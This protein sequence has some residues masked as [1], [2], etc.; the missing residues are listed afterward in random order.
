[1]TKKHFIE[2]AKSIKIAY[3]HVHTADEKNAITYTT[4][5]LCN[6]FARFNPLFDEDRFL[7]ACGIRV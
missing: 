5:L 7:T 2:I 4:Q 3:E 1:M 6:D